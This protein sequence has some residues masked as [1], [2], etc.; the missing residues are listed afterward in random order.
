MRKF[1]LLFLLF[2]SIITSCDS[3]D[4]ENVSERP[5]VYEGMSKAELQSVLGEPLKIE[6]KPEIFDG[7]TMKRLTLEHWEYKKRT[8]VLINDT[9]KNANLN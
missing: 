9:V 7:Q 2:A 1:L 6:I 4:S 3:S 5:L 8:V